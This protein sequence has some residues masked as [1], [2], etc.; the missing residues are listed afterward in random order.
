MM[1]RKFLGAGL[2]DGPAQHCLPVLAFQCF[3]LALLLRLHF[4]IFDSCKSHA[5]S[6]PAFIAASH[7]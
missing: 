7:L 5:L 4:R 6:E 3:D 2:P 1:Q